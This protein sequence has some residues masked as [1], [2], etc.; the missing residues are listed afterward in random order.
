MKKAL[1]VLVLA[2]MAVVVFL[3][4]KCRSDNSST[5][6]TEV[7]SR[8]SPAEGVNRDHGFDRRI[9]YLE[10]TQHAKCRM[11][12]RHITQQEVEE[13]MHNGT[14]NYRKSDVDDRPCP[15]YAVEEMV[16][17][18][19]LRIVFAQCDLKTKVVTV[20]DLDKKWQC[21]CPGDDDKFKNR[22]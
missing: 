3:V 12:C 13:V 18:E 8:T 11:D 4:K 7:R 21:D 20:I 19:K 6:T 22:N 10:Y 1:P 17:G 14:I 5:A 2:V 9:S 16:N 15:T